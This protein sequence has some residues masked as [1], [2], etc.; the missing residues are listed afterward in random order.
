MPLNANARSMEVSFKAKIN[1]DSS[2]AG[3]G[4]AEKE[5][6]QNDSPENQK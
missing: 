4:S 2:S 5:V 1:F 3:L 6:S